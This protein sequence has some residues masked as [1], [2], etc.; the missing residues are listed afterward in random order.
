MLFSIQLNDSEEINSKITNQKS[1]Q[2]KL[3]TQFDMYMEFLTPKTDPDTR[4]AVDFFIE[5]LF[6]YR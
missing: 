1:I 3:L 2:Q 5:N 4:T 6:G